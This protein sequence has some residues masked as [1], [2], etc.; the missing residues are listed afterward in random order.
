M[1]KVIPISQLQ[2]H[3]DNPR[4]FVREEVVSAICEQIKA[5]GEFEERHAPHVR[6]LENSTYQIISGHHRTQGADRAGLKKI[7]CVVVEMTDEQA[8]RELL[9]SNAQDDLKPLEIGLHVL[10]AVDRGKGG[11]GKKGG[12][13]AWSEQMGKT[14]QLV[15]QYV[16]AADVV[17]HE[18]SLSGFLDYAW[19][20]EVIHRAPES[21]WSVLVAAML[22]GEWS[23]EITETRVEAVKQFAI[24]EDL[25]GV[26][27]R[28]VVLER[29]LTTLEFA[30]STL[31]KLI[32]A[33]RRAEN[34]IG[35]YGRVIDAPSYVTALR[36]WLRADGNAWDLRR[37]NKRLRELYVELD[38]AEAEANHRWNHCDWR[39]AIDGLADASVSLLLTDPPYGIEFQSDYRLDRTK[40]H[41]HESLERDGPAAALETGECM[42]AL[43][44]KLTE[45]AHVLC[46]CHWSQESVIRNAITS[47][48]YA[49]R[50]S[51]IWVKNKTGMGD[52]NTT[53]APKHERIIHAVKGSPML[54][55]R[56]PDVLEAER[57]DSDRHPTEKPVTLLVRLIEALTVEGELV[58]DPFAGVASVLVAAKKTKRGYWGCEIDADYYS[59]GAVRLAEGV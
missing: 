22:A 23:K 34:F 7:P 19:Q 26:Y 57:V 20:L 16:N 59:A 35:A 47:A 27:P 32:E 50:G 51:L 11:R 31:S 24:P 29:Y 3:P 38:A 46:F 39:Q 10:K 30:P 58:A 5:K 52:P 6:H 54:F 55:R 40:A 2:P 53:F 48:G 37:I 13:A 18:K 36:D 4:L 43:Y 41:R 56:E 21:D 44:P 14:R 9:L 8:F 25:A 15:Q 42:R 49:I 17:K 28:D 45:N 12:I 33:I 1:I